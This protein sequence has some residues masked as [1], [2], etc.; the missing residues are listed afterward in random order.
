MQMH[1]YTVQSYVCWKFSI[2]NTS[3]EGIQA[4]EYYV[5]RVS[6]CEVSK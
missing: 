3:L 1:L 2:S 5:D 4:Y 6:N